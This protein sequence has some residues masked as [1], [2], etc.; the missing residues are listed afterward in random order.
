[1]IPPPNVPVQVSYK[2]SDFFPFLTGKSGSAIAVDRALGY[3][4]TSYTF[5]PMLSKWGDNWEVWGISTCDVGGERQEWA[6]V[7]GYTG[8]NGPLWAAT[9]DRTTWNDLEVICAAGAAYAPINLPASGTY[10]LRQWGRVAGDHEYFWATE[11]TFGETAF[12]PCWSGEQPTRPVLKQREVWRDRGGGTVRGTIDGD[13]WS[14]PFTITYDY[15][16]MAGLGVGTLWLADDHQFHWCLRSM[17][18]Q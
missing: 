2:F 10:E 3:V 14:G 7:L 18:L 6:V 17:T 15:T 5:S 9:S 13:P 16:V 11:Y 4:V 8:P 12:N 1:V